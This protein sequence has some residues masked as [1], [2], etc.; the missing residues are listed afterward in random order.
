MH[1]YRIM[2]T[3]NEIKIE[4]N[5]IETDIKARLESGYSLASPE[6]MDMLIL[7]ATLKDSLIHAL[8]TALAA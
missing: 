7:R 3:I 8:E 4:I 1:L 5:R 6:I 2:M